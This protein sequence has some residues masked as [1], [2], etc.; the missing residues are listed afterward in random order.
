[1]VG[2]WK[3]IRKLGYVGGNR[4]FCSCFDGGPKI[5]TPV[6][7]KWI[8]NKKVSM[9]SKVSHGHRHETFGFI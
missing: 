9:E 3:T 5:H 4:S 8:K 2:A 1:M 6:A 7:I